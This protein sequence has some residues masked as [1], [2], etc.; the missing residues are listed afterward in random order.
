MQAFQQNFSAGRKRGSRCVLF[1]AVI[2]GVALL[3]QA[4][5]GGSS[6][7]P[8]PPP[9]PSPTPTPPVAVTA[10]S[11]TYPT[12]GEP[13]EA[14]PAGSGIVLVSVTGSQTGVQVFNPNGSGGLQSS[15]V[16]QL[17]ASL[18]ANSPFFA[19]INIF[20]DGSNLGGGI[21]SQGAIFYNLAA[22]ESC[23][24]SGFVVSQGAI[25]ANEGTLDVVVT[26][27]KKFAFIS[28]ED[29]IASGATTRGNIG[30]VALQY[31]AGGNVTTGTTLLGQIPT[32]GNTIAGMTLSPDGTRLYVTSEVTAPG[33]AAA[34]GN[35]PVLA[36]TGCVQQPGSSAPNGLLTVINVS[37]AETSLGPAAVLATV[38]AGC[39]PVR[40]SET[41]DGSTLW[42]AVRGDNRVLA[43][44]TAMLESNPNNA[45]LGFAD[46]G[47]TAPVGIRLFHK[48]QLLAVANSNRFN[49]GTANAAILYVANPAVA[50][51][52]VTIPAGLFPREVNVGSDDATLYLTN[53]NSDTLQVISTTVK[54]N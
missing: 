29:G 44:S 16:N 52:V 20:P 47:G 5:S 27:D 32:G 13:F 49:T 31:D 18:L 46:T 51:V 7:G 21:G 8:P 53:F 37:A 3:L 54:A 42:V 22:L 15:C 45:L 4:C 6:Q 34:G 17:P 38:D 36:R 50:G 24:A 10:T 48:D 1:A 28:N 23:T 2:L 43:F 41:A 19:N 12:A 40:M 26:P 30:V 39:S 35:N 33:T 11:V 25:S 14:L 9:S